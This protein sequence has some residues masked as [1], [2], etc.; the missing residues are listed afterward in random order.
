MNRLASIFAFA[1]VVVLALSAP[2]RAQT[3]TG[4]TIG[5]TTTTFAD[6]D[7]FI[8]V[9]HPEG[10]NL[11]TYDLA[12]FFGQANC[13][14]Q[15]PVYLY[16]A[17]TSQGFAKRG[18]VP[19]GT[20][21]VLVGVN[22]NQQLYFPG[23]K[24]LY[25][26][27]I[28]TFMANGRATIPTD[29]RVLS[30]GQ[31]TIDTSDAGIITSGTT[32]FNL[33]DCS[34]SDSLPQGFDQTIWVTVDNGTDGTI[35]YSTTSTVHVDLTPPPEP[36]NVVVSPG[37]EA[38][39]LKWDTLDVSINTDLQG[40]QILCRRGANLQVFNDG[41]FTPYYNTCKSAVPA[42][43]TGPDAL[44]PLFACSPLL[45]TSTSS[46]RV[47]ILQNGIPYGATVVAIDT[48]GNASTPDLQFAIP[49]KT[50]SFYDVYREGS[51][52]NGGGAAA[53]GFCAVGG[54]PSRRSWIAGGAGL[55]VALALAAARRR[56]RK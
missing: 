24:D 16:V 17:L 14:C 29:A 38:L 44:D 22:C 56:R 54:R 41:T 49:Q 2:A 42:G 52:A 32:P 27:Q 34:A 15:E 33:T 11:G 23:C 43:V 47:K 50:L 6:G 40:Y 31:S 4:G 20:L 9:Q 25:D 51:P 46:Y 10:S 3:A 12:R 53:G 55:G 35:D 1:F 30:S 21:R 48:N 36:S 26:T 13:K 28:T 45:T 8:A 5:T 37:N 18:L 39:T 19:T 7:F